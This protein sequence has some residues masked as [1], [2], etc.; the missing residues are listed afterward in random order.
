MTTLRPEFSRTARKTPPP[1]SLRLS[2]EERANLEAAANGVPL[3]AYIRSVL[4]EQDLPKV[5]RRGA[6]PVAD[7]TELA[8]ALALLGGSRLS[9]N[10]NQLAKAANLGMLP[11]TPD[12]EAN[13]AKACA[14]IAEMR[15]AL[16]T[17]LGLETPKSPGAEP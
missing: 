3:G 8:R 1:F 10:M 6:H 7:H 16:V 14:D 4:F 12:T 9:A 13:L 11:V 15:D 17:A 5:R 2:F